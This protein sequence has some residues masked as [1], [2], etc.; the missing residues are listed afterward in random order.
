[1][2]VR[3]S[4]SSQQCFTRENNPGQGVSCVLSPAQAFVK[5]FLGFSLLPF[6]LTIFFSLTSGSFPLLFYFRYDQL[7][8]LH[9]G[10]T[11]ILA[12]SVVFS[13]SMKRMNFNFLYRSR[14]K[15]MRA[16]HKVQGFKISLIIH[17][18]PHFLFKYF[19]FPIYNWPLIR[20]PCFSGFI[21]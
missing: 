19:T 15:A 3:N 20:F 14:L 21:S 17:F 9:F 1:M 10:V 16:Y 18:S 5:P 11:G 12:F 2:W 7:Y 6:E 8:A 4:L 13:Y